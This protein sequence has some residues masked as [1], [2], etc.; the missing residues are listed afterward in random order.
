MM[1]GP[2]AKT[3]STQSR[4]LR[5]IPFEPGAVSILSDLSERGSRAVDLTR[6][7]HSHKIQPCVRCTV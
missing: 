4:D 5:R 2:L 7:H 1:T 6:A 3:E